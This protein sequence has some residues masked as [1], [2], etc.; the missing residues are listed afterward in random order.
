M[1]SLPRLLIVNYTV[2]GIEVINY[3]DEAEWAGWEHVS[4]H[5][6]ALASVPGTYDA[7]VVL[8]LSPDEQAGYRLVESVVQRWPTAVLHLVTH[9][10]GE[11]VLAHCRELGVS[12][13]FRAL[14]RPHLVMASIEKPPQP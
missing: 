13:I 9:H 6:G 10:E 3:E 1:A 4:A 8:G 5:H 7:V 11:A 12:K 14:D 2:S